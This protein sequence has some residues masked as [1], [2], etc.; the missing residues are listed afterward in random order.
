MQEFLARPANG[1]VF[2]TVRRVRGTEVT[3]AGRLRLDSL[4]RYLQDIA[5]DDFTDSGWEGTYLWTV[6]KIAVAVAGFPRFGDR[7]RLETFCSAIGPRWAERTTII[8]GAGRDLLQATAVWAALSLADGRPA[9]LDPAFA[10]VWG[11]SAG[12]RRASVQLSH[13]RPPAPAEGA[14]WPLR[15]ADFDIAGHV[16]NAI[17]WVAV[18]AVLANL[19]WLPGRAE[20]EYRRQ[21][22]PGSVPSLVVGKGDDY[23]NIWLVD[24]THWLAS[25]RLGRA[26]EM[27]G[28][29]HTLTAKR[30]ELDSSA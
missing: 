5:E 25:A 15:A 10:R 6:R 17:H 22:L 11:T 21:I 24:G 16:N 4:A 28:A 3:P 9:Q 29:C 2:S 30:P 8:S 27:P 23:A 13:P 12:G 7:V 26:L 14:A 18:E 1:R 19:G 20:M